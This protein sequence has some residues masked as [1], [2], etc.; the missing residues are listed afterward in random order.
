MIFFRDCI[1]T[2]K[3][4]SKK[5]MQCHNCTS[6]TFKIMYIAEKDLPPTKKKI[7][8]EGHIFAVCTA[9]DCIHLLAQDEIKH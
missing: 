9:C 5:W 6:K 3:M 4:P 7:K 1:K 2:F 8:I